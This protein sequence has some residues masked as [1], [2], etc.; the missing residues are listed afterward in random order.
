[1]PG[2]I[3]WV[4]PLCAAL[5]FNWANDLGQWVWSWRVLH[6]ALLT[7][8]LMAVVVHAVADVVAC[9]LEKRWP[10]PIASSIAAI[11]AIV[12]VLTE[13][14]KVALAWPAIVVCPGFVLALI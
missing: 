13:S 5:V 1:M 11:T 4:F 8:V 12:F 14:S 3:W 2:V 9:I 10:G 6:G 7:T